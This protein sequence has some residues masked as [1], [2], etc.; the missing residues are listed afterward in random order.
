MGGYDSSLGLK[1][2][3]IDLRE[4]AFYSRQVC[5]MSDQKSYVYGENTYFLTI[6]YFTPNCLLC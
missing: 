1:G 5:L 6:I 3:H 2:N 4:H